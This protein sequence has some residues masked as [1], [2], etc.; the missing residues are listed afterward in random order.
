MAEPSHRLAQEVNGR[1][2]RI[3]L[4]PEEL[5]VI[6]YALVHQAII[7]NKRILT[8]EEVSHETRRNLDRLLAKVG[9]VMESEI[10]DDAVAD[11]VGKSLSNASLAEWLDETPDK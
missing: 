2:Y 9:S 4:T 5:R 3:D 7:I 8:G 11:I 1:Q 10:L 6:E